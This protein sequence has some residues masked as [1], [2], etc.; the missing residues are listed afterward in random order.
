METV[1]VTL[2]ETNDGTW[3]TIPNADALPPNLTTPHPKLCHN[4]ALAQAGHFSKRHREV[5][6]IA[7]A[8]VGEWRCARG[9]GGWGRS[10]DDGSR[11]H[12]SDK[13]E[14]RWS[15]GRSQALYAGLRA[16]L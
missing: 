3:R 16:S 8:P 11:P 7:A 2:S 1:A 6:A 15:G 9:W 10:S 12:T 14:D 4:L 13:S 5:L